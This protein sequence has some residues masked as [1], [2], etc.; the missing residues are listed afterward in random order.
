MDLEL[1]RVRERWWLKRGGRMELEV[2][3]KKGP[4]GVGG[5]YRY[6][7]SLLDSF[8]SLQLPHLNAKVVGDFSEADSNKVSNYDD[9]TILISLLCYL[10]C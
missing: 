7:G 3:L 10:L 9:F 1:D 5:G 6:V 2:G 8:D 4:Y